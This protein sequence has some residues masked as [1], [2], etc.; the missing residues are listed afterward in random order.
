MNKNEIDKIVV[1][2]IRKNETDWPRFWIAVTVVLLGYIII[3]ILGIVN[4][5]SEKQLLN[6][7]MPVTAGWTGAV[8]AFYFSQKNIDSANRS[9]DRLV[10][11]ITPE[12]RL[13]SIPVVSCMI[14]HNKMDVYQNEPDIDKIKLIDGILNKMVEVQQKRLPVLDDK[15]CIKLIIHRSMI[16]HFLAEKYVAKTK[17][18]P[19][20]FTI[21]D[22]RKN[23][24]IYKTISEGIAF[25]RPS[26]TM[27][28]AKREMEQT[29]DCLDVFVTENGKQ[30]G[31]IIGWITNNIITECANT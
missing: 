25:V 19:E 9:L 20:D 14:T 27:S 18:P 2:S 8:I 21:N 12:Q 23:G 11:K 3:L 17:T 5:V 16:D 15:N 30:N 7:I 13:A 4:G 24:V 31:E 10:E 22:L 28:E 29:K 1:N 6:S 26:A